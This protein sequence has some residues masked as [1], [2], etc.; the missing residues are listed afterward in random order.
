MENNRIIQE[1][2]KIRGEIYDIIQALVAEHGLGMVLSIL[3][4]I[5]FIQAT[6]L[7]IHDKEIRKAESWDKIGK[8]IAKIKFI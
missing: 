5:C 2:I 4:D 7:R 6:S 1:A 8:Q 3:E